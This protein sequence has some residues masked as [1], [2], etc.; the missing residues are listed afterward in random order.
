LNFVST[1]K[2][3]RVIFRNTSSVGYLLAGGMAFA[4]LFAY[5]SG[6]PGVFMGHFGTSRQ[7]FSIIFACNIAGLASG[8]ML[9]TRIVGKVGAD[10]MLGYGTALSASAAFGLLIVGWTGA[11]GIVLFAVMQFLAV[12]AL[13]LIY[14]NAIAGLLEHYPRLSG[15]ASALFGVAQFGFGAI[16]GTLVGQFYGGGPRSM[17]TIMAV[18][19]LISFAA[20]KVLTGRGVAAQ[21]P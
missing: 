2:S 11:G 9:N 21:N 7:L 16:A 13:H 20:Q 12:A 8:S 18:T 14:A 17:V 19:S 15:T 4:T 10:R 6:A 5:I 1:L 3:Y